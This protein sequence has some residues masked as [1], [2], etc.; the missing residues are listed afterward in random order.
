MKS[1]GRRNRCALK[2]QEDGIC[3]IH[4]IQWDNFT[5]KLIRD[6]FSWRPR[7]P[8]NQ[9]VRLCT[10]ANLDKPFWSSLFLIRQPVRHTFDQ[11]WKQGET[12]WPVPSSCFRRPSP[13][14]HIYSYPSIH[15]T[16]FLMNMAVNHL[17]K[18]NNKKKICAFMLLFS[19]ILWLCPPP[20]IC[21]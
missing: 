21:F 8:L 14:A 3:S 12:A 20:R 13:T 1:R 10:V 16:M 4:L 11:R 17:E 18:K 15:R 2:R 5:Q 6:T 7:P 19:F 9:S